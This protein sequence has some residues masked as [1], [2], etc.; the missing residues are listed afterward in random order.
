MVWIRS[1]WLA[2]VRIDMPSAPAAEAIDKAI[3]KLAQLSSRK[4]ERG[5]RMAFS[6]DGN[7]R[8]YARKGYQA[9]SDDPEVVNDRCL[10]RVNIRLRCCAFAC[11]LNAGRQVIADRDYFVVALLL[12][13]ALALGGAG[14]YYP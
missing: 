10:A 11:E 13:I 9:V 8:S 14:Y 3:I 12:C 2:S 7:T 5:K 4:T 6:I 1:C